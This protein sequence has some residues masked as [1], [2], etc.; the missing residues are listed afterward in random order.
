MSVQ[1]GQL[2]KRCRIKRVA[3]FG[4]AG[5][6]ESTSARKT[7]S[8]IARAVAKSLMPSVSGQACKPLSNFFSVFC[9]NCSE[10]CESLFLPIDFEADPEKV[11]GKG[12]DTRHPKEHGGSEDQR[13]QW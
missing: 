2:V 10:F 12:R 7:Q 8:S 13:V 1:S 11:G 3:V 5:G 9:I 6:G 4:N